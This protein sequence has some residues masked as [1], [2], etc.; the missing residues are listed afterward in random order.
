LY[1]RISWDQDIW[2]VELSGR[3][4]KA[5]VPQSFIDSTGI[6]GSPQFSPDGKRI[7]FL[8]NRSG[9]KELWV[10]NQD[11]SNSMRLTSMRAPIIG[12]PRW[13]PDG[14]RIMFDANRKGQYELYVVSANGGV[15]QRLTTGSANEAV[16][17]WS[18]DGRWIYFISDR[19]G[20]TQIWKRLWGTSERQAEAVQVT[21]NGG[22]MAVESPDGKSLYYSKAD[23]KPGLW[24]MPVEGGEET[25][26]LGAVKPAYF[27]VT[28]KGIYFV[29]G[30]DRDSRQIHFYSFATH[31]ASPV[32]A[33]AGW[34][35]GG[36]SVSPD[37][38]ILLYAQIDDQGSDLMLVEDFR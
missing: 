18:R 3:G 24:K 11:A 31:R 7:S 34:P 38:R 20:Q 4:G 35:D 13:S 9:S 16:G 19:T 26:I 2:R 15:P 36:M 12:S 6:E 30:A 14:E 1:A 10:C 21:T 32:L 23:G 8:S 5:G 28:T 37:G 33:L 27:A 22:Y 29:P 25:Q 17:R